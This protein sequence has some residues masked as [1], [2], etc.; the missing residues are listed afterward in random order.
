MESLDLTFKEVDKIIKLLISGHIGVMPTDTIYGIVGSA[1]NPDTVA[2]IYLLRKRSSNKPLIVLIS[3]LDDLKKFDV[4][5]SK[6]QTDFLNKI[7]PSPVSIVL[8]CLSENYT[9]LHRGT[10]SL[11][12]RIPKNETLL[13]ILKRVGPLVAPSANIEKGKPSTT[14]VEAKKYFGDQISFYIDGGI[15][16]SKPSTLIEFDGNKMK[17]LR[18]GSFKI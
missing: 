10:Q 11:A 1:L 6:T 9:Y 5:L 2:E 3:A 14:T 12:F 18:Q 15:I 17:V 16:Q 4:I 13:E 7:W 8:P